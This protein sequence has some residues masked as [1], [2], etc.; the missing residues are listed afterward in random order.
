[1]TAA[2]ERRITLRLPTTVDV[3]IAPMA[4]VRWLRA[5]GW[6]EIKGQRA[7]V[8]IFRIGAGR[9]FTEVSFTLDNEDGNTCEYLAEAIQR[10]ATRANVDPCVMADQIA[11][12][13]KG[14]P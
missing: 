7:D 4:I 8:V 11:A 5:N 2:T 3:E 6:R 12:A 14:T 10:I 9:G 1:M 13:D